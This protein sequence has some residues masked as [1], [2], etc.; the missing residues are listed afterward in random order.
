MRAT[1]VTTAPASLSFIPKAI[2]VRFNTMNYQSILRPSSILI[3]ACALLASQ[4]CFGQNQQSRADAVPNDPSLVQYFDFQ[5]QG[6]VIKNKAP[7]PNAAQSNGFL[8]RYWPFPG[9]SPGRRAVYFLP[10]ESIGIPDVN[11]GLHRALTIEA[12]VEP[13]EPVH[14]AD[15]YSD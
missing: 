1:G 10:G 12:W 6:A 13:V 9:R 11:L 3:S 8:E 14:V 4:A 5:D 15:I 2:K 7:Q